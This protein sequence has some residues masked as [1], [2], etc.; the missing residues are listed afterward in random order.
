MPELF[1]IPVLQPLCRS[2]PEIA[3]FTPPQKNAVPEKTDRR[4]LIK[5][6]PTAVKADFFTK[7]KSAKKFHIMRR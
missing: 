3:G 1:W 7:I 4:L 5:K 2:E 6:G